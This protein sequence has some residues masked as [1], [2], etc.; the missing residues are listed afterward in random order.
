M[1]FCIVWREE[2]DS[3]MYEQE[4]KGFESEADAVEA[5]SEVWNLNLCGFSK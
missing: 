1:N 2:S 3:D 5:W 4:F